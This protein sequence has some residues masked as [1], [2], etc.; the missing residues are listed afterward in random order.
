MR[1]SLICSLIAAVVAAL[2]VGLTTQAET[3]APG[4][5]SGHLDAYTAT[6]KAAD[7]SGL[8]RQ[9]FEPVENRQTPDP[10]GGHR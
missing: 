9:G 10:H 4:R 8:A 6:V 7:L 2:C 1:R 5:S 3:A